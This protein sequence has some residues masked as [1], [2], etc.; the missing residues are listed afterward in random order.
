[1]LQ[2]LQDRFKNMT[3][4]L[5]YRTWV[6]LAAIA[7][8]LLGIVLYISMSSKMDNNTQ[9]DTSMQETISVVVAKQDISPR[10]IIKENM[11]EIK[12]IPQNLVPADAITEIKEAVDKP[13]NVQLM[14]GDIVTKRK[15]LM[16]IKMAG[17]T[18]TIPPDC[19]AVTIGIND[20]TG[21]AGFAKP[22]DYV[23][24]VLAT[25]GN[26]GVST[27]LLLQN[28][29]LLAVNKNTVDNNGV[30]PAS[31]GD[32]S[33]KDTPA[34]EKPK[35]DAS[36]SAMVSATLA[37]NPRDVMKV[38]AGAQAG[39]MHLVLRPYKPKDSYTF[40]S[41]FVLQNGNIVKAA[42]Q[43]PAA[44]PPQSH[45]YVPQQS[46]TPPV[47]PQTAP[48]AQAA[49]QAPAAPSGVEVIRGTTV[50]REGA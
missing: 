36:G 33:S 6:I 4:K 29:L 45:S 37:L 32:V 38:I 18:G 25:K 34:A 21:V 49:P 20:I 22:G 39:T 8:I 40:Q 7:S 13:A 1:M 35:H 17:F 26:N 41:E 44:P 15:L 24:I 16:D 46:Y 11:L 48:P 23:D 14:Q 9:A 31:N 50:T 27:Q 42:A 28:V 30:K 47:I 12:E 3:D 10:T 5:G 2:Q 43:T 19:R